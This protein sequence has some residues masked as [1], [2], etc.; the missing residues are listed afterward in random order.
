MA[1]YDI[2]LTPVK[3]AS[4][5]AGRKIKFWDDDDGTTPAVVKNVDGDTLTQPIKVPADGHLTVRFDQ[6]PVYY[7]DNAWGWRRIKRVAGMPATIAGIPAECGTIA[8]IGTGGNL[9]ETVAKGDI[10]DAAT[11]DGTEI[12]AMLS[13]DHTRVNAISAKLDALIASL[14]TG[15]IVSSS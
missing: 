13:A 10:D 15:D 14:K 12:A 8:A 9:D 3:R 1:D 4:F 7:S 11:I 5:D 6:W 2:T